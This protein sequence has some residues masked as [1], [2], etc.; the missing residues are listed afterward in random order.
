M[1]APKDR[2]DNS[3]SLVIGSLRPSTSTNRPW[4]TKSGAFD[5]DNPAQKPCNAVDSFCTKWYIRHMRHEDTI[6]IAAPVDV[7]WRLVEHVE[8]LPSFTPTMTRVERLDD[9]PIHIG[10]RA[11]VKQPGQRPAVWTVTQLDRPKVFAWQTRVTGVTMTGVHDV[12]P[13]DSG[14]TSTLSIELS[15]FGARLLGRLAGA[16][17][18]RLIAEENCAFKRHAETITVGPRPDR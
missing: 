14:C 16:K 4:R 11:R 18:R 15:G 10:S 7:V 6:A 8:G 13:A 12:A 1:T 2:D 5:T 9:G 17:I 3:A